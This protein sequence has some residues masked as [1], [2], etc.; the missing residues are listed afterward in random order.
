MKAYLFCDFGSTNTKLTLVDIEKEEIAATARAYTTVETDVMTGFHKAYAD[1]MKQVDEENLEI[2]RKTACS[3]AAGGLKMVAIGLIESLTAEAAKRSALGAGA[4]VMHTYSGKLNNREAEAIKEADLD[5]ILLAGG[6]DG[7]NSECIIHN[8]QKLADVGIQIPVV[9]AGNKSA[10][11]EVE[12]ILQQGQIEYY[13]AENV[14]PQLN[15]INVESSRELI[16]EVFMGH[17]TKAR[18]MQNVENEISAIVM[19]TPAAV[20]KAAEVLSKGTREEEGLGE[21]AVLDIGGAT[22][23]VHSLAKGL[24]TNAQALMR[25]LREPYAKRTVEGDLGMRYSILSVVENA[26]P[27]M[28]EGFL[29]DQYDY[30]VEEEAQYRREHTDYIAENERELNFDLA[31]AKVCAKVSML[32]H[33]GTIKETYSPMM[34][35]FYE[36]TGKD[37]TPLKTVIGTGGVLAYSQHAKEILQAVSYDPAY[38]NTLCPK[39]ADYYLDASYTLSA[40]GLLAMFDPDM[41]VRMMKKNI[42]KLEDDYGSNQ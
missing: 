28:L 4:K 18:G 9:V 25:G 1:L 15:E 16:R 38:P 22:T 30:D 37:L 29:G 2:V 19:P 14:M 7:G 20:L 31:M 3:S 12:A 40:M 32:R 27:E 33:V 36:Q 6:T 11:D 39:Q 8:A 42:V 24:P 26:T 23:D 41:A 34:G 21:L 13:V 17:I 5:I 10:L 35:M